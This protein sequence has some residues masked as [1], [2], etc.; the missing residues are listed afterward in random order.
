M[1]KI[2]EQWMILA[3]LYKSKMLHTKFGLFKIK[4]TSTKMYTPTN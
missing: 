2:L 4:K 3:N 1:K